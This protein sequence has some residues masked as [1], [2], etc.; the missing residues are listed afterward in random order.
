MDDSMFVERF[1]RLIRRDR[2]FL[3]SLS[4]IRTLVESR[5][6][7]LIRI[8][9]RVALREARNQFRFGYA[10]GHYLVNVSFPTVDLPRYTN[11][12]TD[13]FNSVLHRNT[14]GVRFINSSGT[15]GPTVLSRTSAAIRERILNQ[16]NALAQNGL[17][18]GEITNR[19]RNQI[20]RT[21]SA[22]LDTSYPSIERIVRTEL[23]RHYQG[24]LSM[25]HQ[26]IRNA[27]IDLRRR[28]I[29]ADDDRTRSLHNQLD[30]KFEDA[31]G[32]FRVGG[33]AAPYPGAF[34]VAGLDINCRCSVILDI[35]GETSNDVPLRGLERS[36]RE[37]YE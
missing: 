7:N 13:Q 36:I 26:R 24:G 34:G 19:V 25:Q 4:D 29:A 18:I 12:T 1:S 22:E 32:L 10:S 33:Y 23:K 16:A 9:R 20:L 27:G 17:G 6:S 30:N 31:D 28:W 11:P 14:A 35:D 21:F 2:T 3:Q 15:R 5:T 37:L 8:V